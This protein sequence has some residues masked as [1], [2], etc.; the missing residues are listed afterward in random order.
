MSNY[1]LIANVESCTEED[2]E[3]IATLIDIICWREVN[4]PSLI[5]S[6]FSPININVFINGLLAEVTDLITLYENEDIDIIS[7]PPLLFPD[8]ELQDTFRNYSHIREVDLNL[9]ETDTGYLLF[10][11]NLINLGLTPL[12]QIYDGTISTHVNIINLGKSF[13]FFTNQYTMGYLTSLT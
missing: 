13:H 4:T 6:K 7:I 9:S 5:N 8:S 11:P 1:P 12:Q 2:L 10:N 3:I